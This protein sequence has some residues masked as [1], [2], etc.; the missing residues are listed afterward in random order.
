MTDH[1]VQAEYSPET[2]SLGYHFWVVF[3]D[4]FVKLAKLYITHTHTHTW[5]R[6]R[7][8]CDYFT[9]KGFELQQ[10]NDK[11]SWVGKII[12]TK[13]TRIIIE[14]KSVTYNFMDINMQLKNHICFHKI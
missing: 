1:V 5:E 14:I 2:Y 10:Y 11:G 8:R 4:Q 3:V 9:E 13:P 7:E 12:V 6:E